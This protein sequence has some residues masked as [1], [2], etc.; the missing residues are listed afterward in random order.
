MIWIVFIDAGLNQCQLIWSGG[1]I[2]FCC[3]IYIIEIPT[4]L[5][6]KWTGAA[7][8]AINDLVIAQ[9]NKNYRYVEDVSWECSEICGE[10][11]PDMGV[12]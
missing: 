1:S 7:T 10:C 11:S 8:R 6:I 5:L 9:N 4:T 3:D 2:M 12:L